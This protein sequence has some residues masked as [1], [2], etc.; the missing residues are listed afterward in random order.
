MVWVRRGRCG[1][2]PRSGRETGAICS[3]R[4]ARGRRACFNPRSGRE[5]GAMQPDGSMVYADFVSIRAPVVRPERLVPKPTSKSAA[6]FQS[7]LRS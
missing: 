2:N 7:A 4:W 5:T 1:F 3:F 6:T